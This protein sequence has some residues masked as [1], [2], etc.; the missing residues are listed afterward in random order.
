[1]G[2]RGSSGGRS[3]KSGGG[4]VIGSS[5]EKT[6]TKAE[7]RTGSRFNMNKDRLRKE[8]KKT[9]NKSQTI[10]QA[11]DFIKEQVGLDI[12]KYMNSHSKKF[13]KRG[14]IAIDISDMSR[15]EKIKLANALSLKY[16]PYTGELSGTWLFEIKKKR[17]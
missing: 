12:R 4:N 11:P 13:E 17:K 8:V 14:T 15:T 1:M 16:S 5:P 2:G 6:I 10:N 3:S 7:N 9:T